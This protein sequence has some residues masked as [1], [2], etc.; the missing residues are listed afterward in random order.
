MLANLTTPASRRETRA[1]V[2]A[3][4]EHLSRIAIGPTHTPALYAR[5]LDALV[6]HFE[7]TSEPS[8]TGGNQALA[9]L[10]HD[11]PAPS[12][13]PTFGPA[14]DLVGLLGTPRASRAGSVDWT[15]VRR[16]Y[17][18]RGLTRGRFSSHR[19][20]CSTVRLTRTQLD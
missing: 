1:L 5:V 20:S 12:W 15:Q 8:P 19:R 14:D 4:A 17:C 11:G 2:R 16:Q 7:R 9:D 18:D 13:M 6:G 3:F 10:S